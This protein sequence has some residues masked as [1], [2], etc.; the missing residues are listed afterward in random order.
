MIIWV[1]DPENADPSELVWEADLPSPVGGNIIIIDKIMGYISFL[2]TV[3]VV[4]ILF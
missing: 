4:N 3:N 1:Y 2:R